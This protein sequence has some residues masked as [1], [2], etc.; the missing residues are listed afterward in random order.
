MCGFLNLHAQKTAHT[1]N[2]RI[3]LFKKIRHLLTHKAAHLV[4]TAT[5]LPQTEFAS[6]FYNAANKNALKDIQTTQNSA[7]KSI[8]HLPPLTNTQHLHDTAK[9]DTLN[10]RYQRLL[11]GYAFEKSRIPGNLAIMTRLTRKSTAILLKTPI[12]K[13]EIARK[14]LEYRAATLWNAQSVAARLSE[15]KKAFLEC[16]QEANK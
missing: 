6:L 1:A 9:I 15:N 12:R 10:T 14:S 7:L 2:Y 16:F 5:I 4:Y 8:L 13:K 11:A 3:S